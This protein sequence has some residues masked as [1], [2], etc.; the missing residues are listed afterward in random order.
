ML[1]A[2]TPLDGRYADKTQELRPFLSEAA[3]T[4]Y[5]LHVEIQWLLHLFAWQEKSQLDLKIHLTS[6]QKKTLETLA[7]TV[8]HDHSFAETAKKFEKETNHDVKAIEYTLAEYLRSAGFGDKILSLI[9]FACTSEDINN[10]A[11]ALLLRDAMNKV[12]AP[13]FQS[14][15]DTLR[16][17][18]RTYQDVSMLSRTHGQKATP[19]TLGKEFAIFAYR[20]SRQGEVLHRSKLTGK[21]NGATGNYCAHHV[22]FPNT[23]WEELARDFVSVRLG[24]EFNPLTTQIEPHD[25]IVELCQVLTHVSAIGIDL[26]RD[27]W[28]YISLGYL[29]QKLKANEVGSSTMPHKVNPIDFENAEGN[30]GLAIALSQHLATKLPIS[31]FQRDLS[32]STVLRSLGTLLGYLLVGLLALERG[33]GKIEADQDCI[34]KDLDESWEILGEALQTALRASGLSNAYERI[35]KATRGQALGHTEYLQLVDEASELSEELRKRLRTLRPRD[36]VGLAGE[37]VRRHFS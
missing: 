30:F 10:L 13:R 33:L 12:I 19:T 37:L 8:L 26:C 35:K 14:I 28:G 34:A 29:K 32:D 1:D 22:V 11:Y 27:M 24:L 20:L 2:L 36:Y 3:F 16:N 15:V 4:S 5:R 7:Q 31:R 17:A 21:M 23:D 9:H 25:T 18:A 6:E